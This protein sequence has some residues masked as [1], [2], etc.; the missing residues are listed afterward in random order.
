MKVA[1]IPVTPFQQNCSL[2]VCEQT[3]RAAVVDPGGDL[4]L[5]LDA[6]NE[7]DISDIATALA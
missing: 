4:E 7:Q 6:V 2:L 1:V 5:I 3:N